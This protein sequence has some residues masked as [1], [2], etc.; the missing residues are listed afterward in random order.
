[1]WVNLS[2]MGLYMFCD[3]VKF[4]FTFEAILVKI[5]QVFILMKATLESKQVYWTV[6]PRK[7]ETK[8]NKKYYNKK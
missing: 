5:Q 8:Q 7:N 2:Q 4:N 3:S 1:M 6:L